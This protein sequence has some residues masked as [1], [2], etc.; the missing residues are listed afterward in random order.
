MGRSAAPPT[1]R[2]PRAPPSPGLKAVAYRLATERTSV[3]VE[4]GPTVEVQPIGAWP[5]YRTAVGLVAAFYA[6]AP[7]GEITALRELYA[8][9][10]AE[11]GRA[12]GRERGEISG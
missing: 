8:F 7:A 10:V 4:D 2:S 11:I 9:F 6:A 1:G 5:I 3:T 12:S